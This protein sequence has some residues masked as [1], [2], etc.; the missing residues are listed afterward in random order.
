[1]PVFWSGDDDD[2]LR[3]ALA[4]VA[5]DP[6]REVLF[7]HEGHGQR[8]LASDRMVGELPA[9]D[10]AGGTAAWLA[11]LAG[12]NALAGD[13]A[14]LWHDAVADGLSWS[15][16]QRRAVLRLFADHGLLVVHGNDAAL[17]A[18][19]ATFYEQLWAQRDQLRDAARRGGRQLTAAGFAAAVTE[20]SIQRF[21]HLGR[22]G[23]RQPLAAE[24]AGVLPDAATLRPGVV[25][26][27]LVQDW[28]F[29]PA[30]VVVGPGEVAYLKQLAPAYEAFGLPRAPLL[31]RLFAQLGPAGRGAFTAWAMDL[32]DREPESGEDKLEAVAQRAAAASRSGVQA[33]LREEGGVGPERLPALTDQVLQRWARHLE[34]LL[35]R[36]QKRQRADSGAG[37]PSWV[38]P[39]G[40]RQ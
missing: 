19:A 6:D 15:R 22:E 23:R 2:D 20:P 33:V 36:E 18:A 16:L 4:P 31:P 14:R 12:R 25:A 37:Q 5:W 21:L 34:G 30:G 28:L 26:R 3:E 35:R 17:H 40:R 7:R 8:G 1:V 29:R 32:A 9:P 10:I 27:S 11:G 13:L 39:E 24:H 38:R